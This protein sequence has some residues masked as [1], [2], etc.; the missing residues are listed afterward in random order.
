MRLFVLLV[1]SACLTEGRLVAQAEICETLAEHSGA[2][3]ESTWQSVNDNVM[4]GRSSGGVELENGVVTFA[5][6]T[7]TNGGGFSSI[8]LRVQR[9]TLTGADYLK[10]QVKRDARAYSMT[11]RTNLRSYGRRVAFRGPLLGAPEGG[12]GEGVLSFETLEASIWGRSVPDAKFD[13]GEVIELGMIIYDGND[14]PFEIQFKQIEA[15][16]RPIP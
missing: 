7:N 4:G 11:L 5:G 9:G 2:A 16:V 6:V 8:R 10:V 1:L 12:W 13:P 3:E 14:G 15:C